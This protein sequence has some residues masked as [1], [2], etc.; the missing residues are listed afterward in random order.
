MSGFKI[1]VSINSDIFHAWEYYF[2]QINGWW[3]EEFHTSPKTKRF[4]ID[5]F[6]GGKVYEDFGEGCGLVWGEVIGVDYPHSLQVKGYLTRD[7]GGPGMTFEKFSFQPENSGS[8]VTYNLDCIGDLPEKIVTSLK[9]GWQEILG[10]HFKAYCEK[11][12]K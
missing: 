9:K 10:K 12:E 11:R 7:F 8:I 1:S 2:N 3:P 5:T 4:R 6:I